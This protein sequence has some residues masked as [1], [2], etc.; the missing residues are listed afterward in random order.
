MMVET[1]GRPAQE[2]S[3]GRISTMR[4]QTWPKAWL[5]TTTRTSS[6]ARGRQAARS[7]VGVN[8]AGKG[9]PGR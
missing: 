5:G 4:P 2:P 6:A 1:L 3:C 8:S 9:T 7:P